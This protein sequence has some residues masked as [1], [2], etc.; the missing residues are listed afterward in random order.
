DPGGEIVVGERDDAVEQRQAKVGDGEPAEE[1]E[2]AWD[3]YAVHQDLEQ[4]DAESVERGG[5]DN[6]EDDEWDPAAVRPSVGPEPAEDL[7]NGAGWRGWDDGG[8][9]VHAE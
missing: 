5:E 2:V 1:G 3:Q 9:A 4:P 7:A 8:A 6:E